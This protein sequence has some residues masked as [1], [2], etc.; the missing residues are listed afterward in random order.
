M[1]LVRPYEVCKA[2]PPSPYDGLVAR[3]DFDVVVFGATSVTGRNVAAYLADRASGAGRTWAAAARDA[4]KLGEV[5]S[6]VGVRGAE[7]ITA[8]VTDATSL[9]AM[10]S[11]AT[12]VLN[13]VGP[14]AA[15]GR[16]VIDACIAGGAH[17]VDLSGEMPFVS[18]TTRDLHASAEAS[19]VKVVQVCG[20]EA[21]PA[22]L[23][24]A[25]AAAVA[26]D[27][28][29]DDLASAEVAVRTLKMPGGLPRPSD[30]LSGGTM[31]SLAL[32]VGEDDADRLLD[33]SCLVFDESRCDE[34]RSVSPI[35]I[36]PGRTSDG[37]VMGPMAPAAFINPA[38]IHRS[39]ALDEPA[40]PVFSYR[41]GMALDGGWAS[42][43]LR[44]AA[45]GVLSAVQ[46]GAATAAGSRPEIRKRISSVLE[47]VL[48]ASGFGPSGD[49]LEDWLWRMDVNALTTSGDAVHVG[50]EGDGHPGYLA[51]ARMLGE[52]GLILAEEGA[53]PDRAGCL[54]PALA[55]GLDST[56]RF[57]KAGLRFSVA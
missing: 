24:V 22:D 41:E 12:V 31:Q 10:A 50:I 49:R 43:P 4:Q 11:R 20:F 42:M 26:R 14:Y 34:I 32:A 15:H 44:L 35:S 13:L 17:Y 37:A 8:D 48:P 46:A 54:T 55:I 18:R 5:L 29:A 9:E 57:A 38:V 40:R 45:A 47:R 2:P 36:A 16:P 19:G 51:T 27:R 30:V 28:H 1:R 39:A 7:T 6:L 33:P 21:L 3:R 52:A 23:G 53:S 56:D 25:M